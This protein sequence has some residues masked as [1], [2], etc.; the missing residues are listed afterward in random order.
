MVSTLRVQES[1]TVPVEAGR[2][3]DTVL[4]EPLPRIFSRRF[5]PLPAIREVRDQAGDWSAPGQSRTI[6]TTDGGTMR[7]QLTVVE[8]P[9]HF[10]Y[11]ITDI[12]GPMKA[13]VGSADGEWRFEP[14]SK[15]V[16]ITWAWTLHPASP[17]AALAM[18]V[19]GRLW[20]GYARRALERVEGLL[21][22]S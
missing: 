22:G 16:R 15:G 12:T 3:F 4:S 5:G 17:V 20:K 19:F 13:L 21:L 9:S 7:E 2:A 6:V 18:P 11:R 1:R 10:G 8:R 14:A